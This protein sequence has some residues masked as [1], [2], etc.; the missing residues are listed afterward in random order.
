[1]KKVI[2]ICTLFFFLSAIFFVACKKGNDITSTTKSSSLLTRTVTA[3]LSVNR[4]YGFLVFE[5][6][7]NLDNYKS[8]L[9]GNT[10]G[11]VRAYLNSIEFNSLGKTL[12]ESISDQAEVTEE[13]AISYLLNTSGVV[14][15]K[16]VVMKQINQNE[17]QNYWDFFLT[18]NSSKLN[19]DNYSSLSAGT[20][21]SSIMNKFA[22]GQ[23]LEGGLFE[24]IANNPNGYEA[25]S[26]HSR[27]KFWGWNDIEVRL[28]NCP[29]S[30]NCICKKHYQRY[31]VFWTWTGDDRVTYEKVDSACS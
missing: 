23:E 8:Q 17:S 27:T 6:I 12:Y 19:T 11:D 14:Q 18:M 2:I 31:T 20:F 5:N 26:A 13:Q 10:H 4:D 28:V 3:T 21:S 29:D 9:V 22:C 30:P 7:E 24:Y 15:I 1:M 25:T 16:N